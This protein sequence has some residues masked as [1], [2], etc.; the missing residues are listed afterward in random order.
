MSAE[1][2]IG[3]ELVGRIVSLEI[4]CEP[5]LRRRPPSWTPGARWQ[6]QATLKLSPE[7]PEP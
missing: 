2:R 4:R 7:N 6:M 5:P 3:G 1:L